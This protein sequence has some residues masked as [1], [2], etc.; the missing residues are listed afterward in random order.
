MAF[1][2]SLK[3]IRC[4]VFSIIVLLV[5]HP[6]IAQPVQP[7]NKYAA[8]SDFHIH[9]TFKNYFRYVEHPDSLVLHA[10]N[11][12][13]LNKKYGQTAWKPYAKNVKAK[14]KGKESNMGNYDQANYIN[15]KD[16]D[17]SVLCMSITPPEKIMLSTK[18]D[19]WLNKKLVTH[20]SME[21]QGVLADA[22]NSSFNEFLGEY[23]FVIN[24]D[25]V[26]NNS[27]IKLAKNNE[28]LK[29]IIRDGGIGLVM[30][31][32]GGHVLFG[33]KAFGSK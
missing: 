23:N 5:N 33:T 30:T 31:I 24:Q 8:F 2:T 19:R 17:S 18:S 22:G 25:S 29:R 12:S 26:H 27:K 16:R 14:R 20:M 3:K 13:F 32:E 6:G 21:R 10:D 1:L 7:D 28:D 9:T 15:L 11:P 4:F